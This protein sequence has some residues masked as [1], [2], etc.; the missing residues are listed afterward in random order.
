MA[1]KLN[2]GI[3]SVLAGKWVIGGLVTLLAMAIAFV[4]IML[5]VSG[6][7]G[8]DAPLPRRGSIEATTDQGA[9]GDITETGDQLHHGKGRRHHSDRLG[10]LEARGRIPKM[11]RKRSE[12]WPRSAND[13]KRNS[14][15]SRS[16]SSRPSHAP[17]G[18]S[19]YGLTPATEGDRE[20]ETIP[21]AETL[22]QSGEATSLPDPVTAAR[23]VA[24]HGRTPA[25]RNRHSCD[26]DLGDRFRTA[27]DCPRAGHDT[28]PRQPNGH[29]RS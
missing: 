27:G 1:L 2:P 5:F 23:P 6:I 24:G 8:R 19:L 13:R 10:W 25:C 3:G 16:W 29:A 12:D 22:P 26:D 9:V 11:T 14:A 18:Q 28:G 4:V 17:L 15:V 21:P 7:P 20:R